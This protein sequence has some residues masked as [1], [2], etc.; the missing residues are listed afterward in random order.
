[1][2]DAGSRA[3]VGTLVVVEGALIP[4]LD[5]GELLDAHARSGATATVVVEVDRR[6][7]PVTGERPR[8]PGGVYVFDRRVLDAIP[9]R[10]FQ[11]IKESLLE[12][13]YR[14]GERVLAHEVVGVAPRVLNYETYAAVN[15]W[16]VARIAA[17]PAPP[18]EYVRA[19]DGVRHATA[20][21]HPRARIVGPVL[22]GP[23]ADVGAGAVIV[24]PTVVGARGIVARDALVARSILWD[25]CVV[26][27]GAIVDE[28]LLTR[29]AVV[30]HGERHAG[31]VCLRE[32]PRSVQT[33]I[34][35]PAAPAPR[36]A[37]PVLALPV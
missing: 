34:P 4:S 36:R 35:L 21:V 7:N 33:W 12:R 32:A 1:V 13:L 14:A 23:G 3:G 26:G 5:L 27:A 15:A 19:E 9:A 20:S 22:I 2:R 28:S 18:D 29:G 31:A 25:D 37:S 16:I 30:A 10:G 6:H 17:E 11:D 8:T 24:G